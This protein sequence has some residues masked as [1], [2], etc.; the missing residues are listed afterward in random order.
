MFS[1]IEKQ[2]YYHRA[3]EFLVILRKKPIKY[4]L[5]L[6]CFILDWINIYIFL[7]FEMLVYTNVLYFMG[8]DKISY[9][10]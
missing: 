3:I 10:L 9:Y 2:T 1:L 6:G 4:Y 8:V 5:F 7:L